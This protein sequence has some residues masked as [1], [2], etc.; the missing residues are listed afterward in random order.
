MLYLAVD[1]ASWFL[2][3]PLV[4]IVAAVAISRFANSFFR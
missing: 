4:L 2:I 3:A 1:K